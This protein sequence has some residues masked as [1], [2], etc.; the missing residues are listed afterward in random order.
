MLLRFERVLVGP[1]PAELEAALTEA[2]RAANRGCRVRVVRWTA[3]ETK[4]LLAHVRRAPAGY[5]QWNGPGER[6]Q[7]GMT[8]GGET[9]SAVAV[10]WWTDAARRVHFRIGA[11][12]VYTAAAGALENLFTPYVTRPPLWWTEPENIY[13]SG[14]PACL[15]AVCRCG[16][17]GDP[18]S[19]GWMGTHCAACHDRAEETGQPLAP[20]GEP[21]RTVLV[22]H[23]GFAGP[24]GF[25][26]DGRT[27]VSAGRGNNQLLAWNLAAGTA[28][29]LIAS[30]E[31]IRALAVAPESGEIA[32]GFESGR[33][34]RL[35]LDRGQR[36]PLLLPT[37]GRGELVSLAYSPDGSLLAAGWYG[38]V[39]L[40]DSASG[41]QRAHLAE[42]PQTLKPGRY[43]AFSPNGRVLTVC[44]SRLGV[45]ALWEWE[46][47]QVREVPIPASGAAVHYGV[48]SPDGETLA[49]VASFPQER[50]HLVATTTGE[51]FATLPEARVNDLAI[52]PA[53]DVLAVVSQEESLRLY[54]TRDG[55]P[56]GR[57][58]WH[59]MPM[60]AVAFAPDGRWLATS[61]DDGRVKLWPVRDLVAFAR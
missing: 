41:V 9:R 55:R 16:A 60:N 32:V 22:S 18:D 2:A 36:Q 59:A 14:Q 54:S 57:F 52:S 11:D 1:T 39:A 43:V 40:L 12:R 38:R 7:R 4:K 48:V 34:D 46:A 28:R 23:W 15:V 25:T 56:L 42:G 21:A 61:S 8:P 58:N 20:P 44:T 51:A 13:L 6:R 53:G 17:A 26:P 33:I 29:E 45:L 35:D 49:I 3:A 5:R 27:L 50:I 30:G 31:P 47:G 37:S 19:L 10:A 24:L